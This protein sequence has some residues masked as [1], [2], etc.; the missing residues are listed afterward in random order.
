MLPKG[1]E[2]KK[3]RLRHRVTCPADVERGRPGCHRTPLSGETLPPESL[4]G[5]AKPVAASSRYIASIQRPMLCA[6]KKK[7][8]LGFVIMVNGNQKGGK[9][10]I[11]GM[12]HVD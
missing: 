1:M 12:E 4:S 9:V 5:A 8:T 11:I 6:M 10:V 3:G 2:A 7:L